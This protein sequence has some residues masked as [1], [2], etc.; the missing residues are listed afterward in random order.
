M[1]IGRA[2]LGT[3][4]RLLDRVLCVVGA[5][6]FAQAPEFMQQY[7][8]RLG[9]HLDEARRQLQQF[10]HVA[11]Q[12]GL[13]LDGLVAR[14]AGSQEP[15][16]VRLGGVIRDTV[17]R[18]DALAAAQH[19]LQDA[20]GWTRPFVFLHTVDFDIARATAS[21]FKPGVPTTLEGLVYALAGMLA[22][23]LAYHAGVKFPVSRILRAR[24]AARAA[25]K[26]RPA[27]PDQPARGAA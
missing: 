2:V 27:A 19:A 5:V 6:L 13:T 3:G 14:S 26:A 15:T 1:K 20:S 8:Q 17:E 16:V 11:T 4:E 10:E 25:A 23:L 7:L 18:V 9:G 22:L 21:V 24:A 12:S